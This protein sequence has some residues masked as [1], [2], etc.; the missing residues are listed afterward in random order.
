MAVEFKTLVEAVSLSLKM[1]ESEA[2]FRKAAQIDSQS[3]STGPITLELRSLGL[4]FPK[5][6]YF[7]DNFK[8]VPPSELARL[9]SFSL[10]YNP[11]GSDGAITFIQALPTSLQELGMVGCDIGEEGGEAILEWTKQASSLRML[12]IEQNHFSNTLKAEFRNVFPGVYI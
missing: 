2:C 5:A 12:C 10:S 11:I 9:R 1:C 4:T 6:G 3:E 7:S 8:Q